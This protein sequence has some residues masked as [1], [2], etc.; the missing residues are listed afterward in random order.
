[1]T[2][3]AYFDCNA[4]PPIEP[5]VLDVVVRY[6]RDEFGNA[7]SR[8][9]DRGITA[10][11]AVQSARQAVAQQ[12]GADPSEVIFTSGATEAN[13][14]AILGLRHFAVREGRRHIVTTAIEHKAV[15]EPIEYLI[16]KGFEVTR[17]LPDANG[18][19]PAERVLAAVRPDTLLVS[20]MQTNN[21]TGVIQPLAAVADGLAGHQAYFHTDAAQGF[22]KDEGDLSNPRLDLIS[23]SGHKIYGPMGVGALVTR[24]RGFAKTPLNPLA[25]GGGQERGLRP[26]TAPVALIAGLGAAA[27]IAGR[28]AVARR[29]AVVAMRAQALA[30]LAELDAIIIG[31]AAPRSMPHVINATIP[32]VD[33]E[34][35]MLTVKPWI[36]ISNGSACTSH[37]YAPSH[38]LEAMGVEKAQ[39]DGAVRLSWCHLTSSV[40]WP[41]VV[42]AVRQLRGA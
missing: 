30:A 40:D 17:I 1:M 2:E 42:N 9:H 27:S 36:A 22:G 38:V 8:T 3:P 23:I 6:M 39:I 21:E 14:L 32:G 19:V 13:N 16:T 20:M 25:Y 29:R 24:R 11:R 4:T 5:E 41:A 28:D 37:S 26:G 34:A 7:G 15:L 35:L 10:S 33:S 12:V 18:E 31:G